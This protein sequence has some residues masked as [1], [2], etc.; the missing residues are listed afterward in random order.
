MVRD[1]V[2]KEGRPRRIAT[3][4]AMS[5]SVE[6][7]VQKTPEALAALCA[8]QQKTIRDL[9]KEKFNRGSDVNKMK[10]TVKGMGELMDA[11]QADFT[12]QMQAAR[13]LIASLH[14]YKTQ[15]EADLG[16]EVHMMRDAAALVETNETRF[17]TLIT[18]SRF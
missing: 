18:A 17:E 13:A 1:A 10:K 15:F 9:E 8:T 12:E 5:A 14:V 4:L 11:Q 2:L 6:V 16:S 7:P 3:V